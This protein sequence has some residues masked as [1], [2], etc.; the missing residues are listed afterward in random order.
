MPVVGLLPEPGAAASSGPAAATDDRASG[1][2]SGSSGFF[3]S[4]VNKLPSPPAVPALQLLAEVPAE[5]PLP[6]GVHPAF[7]DKQVEGWVKFIAALVTLA[8]VLVVLLLLRD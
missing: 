5:A 3:P 4:T 7:F 2:S 6:P 8:L 1:E